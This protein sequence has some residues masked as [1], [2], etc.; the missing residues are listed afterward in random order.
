MRLIDA[1]K[2]QAK[3]Y[4]Q[5]SEH[6]I[7]Y[8]G[9]QAVYD[10]KDVLAYDIESAETVEAI[11][12]EWLK[13]FAKQFEERAPK[14]SKPI[15]MVIEDVIDFWEFQNDDIPD[16]NKPKDWKERK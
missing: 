14:M 13:E 4:L 1:D 10:Y 11:P 15:W 7:G 5:R 9:T 3:H 6:P 16:P 8:E 2:L 12:I